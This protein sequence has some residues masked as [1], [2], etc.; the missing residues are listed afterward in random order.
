VLVSNRAFK[1]FGDEPFFLPSLELSMVLVGPKY[2]D[3]LKDGDGRLSAVAGVNNFLETE[4][5]IGHNIIKD[6]DYHALVVRRDMTRHLGHLI[7]SVADEIKVALGEVL[8]PLLDTHGNVLI[9]IRLVCYLSN[10]HFFDRMDSP[11]NNA[12]SSTSHRP[13]CQSSYRWCSLLPRS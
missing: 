2:L 12:T 11:Q 5:T 4:Y 8:D 6:G 3:A 1:Q 10:L 9:S 7:P 13:R